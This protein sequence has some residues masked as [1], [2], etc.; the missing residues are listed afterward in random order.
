MLGTLALLVSLATD[1]P[2]PPPPMVPANTPPSEQPPQPPP[3]P[4]PPPAPAPYAPPPPTYYQPPPAE[5]EPLEDEG[6]GAGVRILGSVG[7]AAL[8]AGAT[9]VGYYFITT[10]RCGT[11]D[12]SFG[13][14]FLGIAA[15]A[16]GYTAIMLSGWGGHRLFG[17]KSSLGWSA[18]GTGAGA[19]VGLAIFSVIGVSAARSGGLPVWAYALATTV[20]AAIGSGTMQEIGNFLVLKERRLVLVPMPTRDGGMVALAGTF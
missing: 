6:P 14:S 1:A 16:L 5:A 15:T 7:F 8:G 13:L 2:L 19:L 3:P 11:L 18:L 20:G 4:P 9:T 12:C 17:G 10:T